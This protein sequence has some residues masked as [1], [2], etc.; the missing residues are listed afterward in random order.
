MELLTILSAVVAAV[1]TAWTWREQH[2]NVQRLQRDHAAA[3]YVNPLLLAAQQLE[4]RIDG[5][6]DGRELALNKREARGHDGFGSDAAIETLW[7]CA[8][9]FSWSAVNVR[10]GPYTRDPRVI[11][12]LVRIARTFDDRERF[13]DTAFCFS[14]PE[15]QSLADTVLRRL[16]QAMVQAGETSS[17]LTEFGVMSAVDFE[18]EVRNAQSERAGLYTCRSVHDT[19]A[20]I[21]RA[22]RV[23]RLEGRARL[24]A[25]RKLLRPLLEH[26]ER[27]E[28]FSVSLRDLRR[29]ALEHLGEA[30]RADETSPRIL[31][32]TNGRLR[33]SIPEIREHRELADRLAAVM[34]AY[35]EV[36]D[37][38]M[39]VLAGSMTIR[40]RPVLDG[41]ALQMKLLGAVEKEV[42]RPIS[43]A[44]R[45]PRRSAR[46]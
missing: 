11:E 19:I 26:L 29:T 16:G 30:E 6:L 1:W 25:V 15:Q 43:V 18:R 23:N 46:A 45:R 34:R 35:E 12:L 5:L 27:V 41:E 17:A 20:A 39:N 40:H 4:R 8:V 42:R 22:A 7:M 21:D 33:V 28:G 14:V 2:R 38:R 10:Y 36:D 24:D 37:A 3:L 31:H 9:F 13:A 44:P 32:R